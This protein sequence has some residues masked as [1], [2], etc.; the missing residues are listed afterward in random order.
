M[1]LNILKSRTLYL[2]EILLL[3]PCYPFLK[4]AGNK[5]RKNII[6][7]PPH[8]EYLEFGTNSSNP[9][10]LIIGES[11][12]AGVGASKKETTFGSMMAETLLDNYNIFN[13]GKNGLKSSRLLT[14]YEK[15]ESK[16]PDSF[17]KCIVLIGA[18]D[19]FQFSSPTKFTKGLNDFIHFVEKEKACD[20]FIIPLI[21]PVH[22]FPAIPKII[23]FF[24]KIHR[25]ILSLE[26]KNIAKN[27]PKVSFI[28]QNEKYE[29]AFFAT[30]GIHPS[31]V[32][33]RLMTDLVSIYIKEKGDQT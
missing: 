28:N 30:D 22:H 32:G 33:Y 8:S 6:K 9:N 23:R 12:A 14:L 16:L 1:N 7:L 15:N 20:Q 21:P 17:G 2:F 19:C 31:D 13:I 11:T 10:L 3:I 26:V 5:L 29:A 24:L 25:E 4:S 27:N 18:N